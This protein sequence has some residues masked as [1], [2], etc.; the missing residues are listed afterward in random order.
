MSITR[1]PYTINTDGW[2]VVDSA[3]FT[4]GQR[5][6][7]EFSAGSARCAPHMSETAPISGDEY[8]HKTVRTAKY[9]GRYVRTMRSNYN[10]HEVAVVWVAHLDHETRCAPHCVAA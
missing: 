6:T 5:V 2:T 3:D 4:P 7:V 10:G 1:R 8:G 9:A